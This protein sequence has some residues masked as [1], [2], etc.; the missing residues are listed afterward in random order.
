MSGLGITLADGHSVFLMAA[1]AAGS[2]KTLTLIGDPEEAE[3]SE[4]FFP[5]LPPIDEGTGG[6]MGHMASGAYGEKKHSNK[7]RGKRS[8][9]L[10]VELPPRNSGGR[11]DLAV[12][13]TPLAG[14]LPRLMAEIFAT[15][16]H[17]NV[18]S[19]FV[20][21][22]NAAYV[23]NMARPDDGEAVENL[24][25]PPTFSE[26]LPNEHVE[27]ERNGKRNLQPPPPAPPHDR[28]WGHAIQVSS[29]QEAML[30]LESARSRAASE[31]PTESRRRKP[32]HFLSR[33]GVK[34]VNR[35][36]SEESISEMVTVELPEERPGD[37][38]PTALAELVRAHASTTGLA[39]EIEADGLLGMIRGCLQDTSKVSR[40][41][42]CVTFGK[43][44]LRG[45]TK[46]NYRTTSIFVIS[47][48]SHLTAG[49]P[50][51]SHLS[52]S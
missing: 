15:L 39:K 49:R 28:L 19:A 7:E 11:G 30:I 22:V 20:V 43:T 33:V 3:A 21:W 5:A 38:W 35:S 31:T 29:A 27:D 24:L 52:K 26:H 41:D 51:F 50:P 23:S 10:S 48:D 2:G 13:I 18:Q 32:G 34:V 25:S 47:Y 6:A 9:S 42:I 37:S 40:I 44:I 36:T 16:S 12:S 1:G 4:G 17:R 46:E 14:I 8:S 45:P